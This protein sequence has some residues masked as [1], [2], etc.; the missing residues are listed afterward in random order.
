MSLGSALESS[1]HGSCSLDTNLRQ[2]SAFKWLS[3]V[4]GGGCGGCVCAGRRV[5]RVCV[6]REEGV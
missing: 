3:C 4:Q 6:C 2:L 1:R 5:W